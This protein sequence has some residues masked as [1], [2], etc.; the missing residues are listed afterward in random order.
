M[1]K[2]IVTIALTMSFN[3]MAISEYRAEKI[4]TVMDESVGIHAY[5]GF[6]GINA[7]HV[8]DEVETIPQEIKDLIVDAHTEGD[9]FGLKGFNSSRLTWIIKDKH[10]KCLA[11]FGY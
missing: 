7:L 8:L 2:L 11:Y 3:A 1:K 6:F 10:T 4:C 5:N 9:A